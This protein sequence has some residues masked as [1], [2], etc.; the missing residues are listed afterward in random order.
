MSENAVVISA[1]E[2]TAG[3]GEVSVFFRPHS[4]PGTVNEW[5]DN[6]TE[7]GV[8]AAVRHIDDGPHSGCSAI[9]FACVVTSVG[10][11]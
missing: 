11:R 3:L 4:K 7:P 5:E 10:E 2:P 8:N 1:D 9:S 6:E